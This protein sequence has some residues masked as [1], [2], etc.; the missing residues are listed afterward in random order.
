[1]AAVKLLVTAVPSRII[2]D[3]RPVSPSEPIP[4]V[5][6]GLKAPFAFAEYW[7]DTVQRSV[8]FLDV[9]RK[10]GN[11]YVERTH[12]AVPNVLNFEAKLVVDGRTLAKPRQ[13]RPG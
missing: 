13:L 8:L 12:E 1:M 11:A 3:S 2:E 7:I 10:R 5:D 6:I 4:A 9:L